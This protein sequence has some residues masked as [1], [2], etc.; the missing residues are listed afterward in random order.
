MLNGKT[1]NQIR[2]KFRKECL[3]NMSFKLF[4][5]DYWLAREMSS[6]SKSI[7]ILHRVLDYV[8]FKI[9]EKSFGTMMY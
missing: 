2:F 3:E 9:I 4:T 8:P 5:D 7:T 1:Y 6:S